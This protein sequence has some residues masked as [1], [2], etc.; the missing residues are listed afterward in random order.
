MV[1]RQEYANMYLLAVMVAPD[2]TLLSV[3]WRPVLTVLRPQAP[4][5]GRASLAGAEWWFWRLGFQ[6]AGA[7]CVSPSVRISEETVHRQVAKEPNC[8]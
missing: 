8:P 6:A 4:H 2:P 7:G 1:D 3:C 5:G